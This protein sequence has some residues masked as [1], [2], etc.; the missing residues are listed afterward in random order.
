MQFKLEICADSVESAIIAQQAGADRIE[1]CENLAEGGTTP[2][3]GK[4]FSARANLDIALNVIIRP[5]GSDFLY[6]DTEFDIMRRDIELCGEAGIDGVVLGIL[7]N[8]G[9]ID[10]DRTAR[11][12]ELADTM[13]VTFHRAFDM[14]SDPVKGLEDII[15]TGASRLLSSGQKNRAF[16]GVGLLASLV[17]LAGKRII[18]MPGGGINVNNIAE[19]AHISMASEFHLTGRKAIS[20]EMT[21]RRN[22]IMMGG[23]QGQDEYRRT[24][25]D[26]E[27][28]RKIVEI[29][30]MI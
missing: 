7:R 9:T 8:D 14:C 24:I 6:S 22:G 27:T 25:A 3:P 20:S 10:T 12:V 13:P 16:E 18:V 26:E 11:L 29:L 28:I 21:F 4:I 2:S 23:I 17:E 1:L 30:K 15:D 19:I 5:R